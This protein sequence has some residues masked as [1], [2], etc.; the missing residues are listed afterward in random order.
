M[1]TKFNTAVQTTEA[2]VNN[3]NIT[4]ED[5]FYMADDWRLFWSDSNVLF[6][7]SSSGLLAGMFDSSNAT[8]C[9]SRLIQVN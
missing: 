4:S 2:V 3:D 1:H 7:R 9:G 6:F 8:K 5:T